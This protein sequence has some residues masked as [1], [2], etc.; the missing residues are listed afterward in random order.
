M[1]R[2]MAGLG[3][4]FL[5]G[6]FPLAATQPASEPASCPLHVQITDEDG[7]ALPKAFVFIHNERGTNQQATPDRTGQ[8]KASLRPGLYDLFVAAPGFVP[9]AQIVD[10][11]S[12]KPQNL[13]LMMALDAEH[14]EGDK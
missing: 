4:A 7:T 1:L 12:C 2:W 8:V 9:T 10:L 14:T 5:A 3:F 6:T 11:R 13:N